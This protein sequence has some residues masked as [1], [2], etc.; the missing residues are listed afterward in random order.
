MALLA[1]HAQE[2]VHE[3][4][5][6]QERLELLAHVLRQRAVFCRKVPLLP[7]PRANPRPTTPQM[8]TTIKRHSLASRR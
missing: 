8:W 2:A 3:H 1:H 5:A 4:A 7:T 6:A